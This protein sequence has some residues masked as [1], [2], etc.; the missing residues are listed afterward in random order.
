[1]D[2]GG[3]GGGG[4][5]T[6]EDGE[7]AAYR[8]RGRDTERAWVDLHREAASGAGLDGSASRVLPMLRLFFVSSVV[9]VCTSVG[10]RHGV[11]ERHRR[12]QRGRWVEEGGRRRA[13]DKIERDGR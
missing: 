6:D 13:A 12:G 7:A 4:I 8:A 3:G 1:M 10:Q 11:S 5:G 2:W 9:D